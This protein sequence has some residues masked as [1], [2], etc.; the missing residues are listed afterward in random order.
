M[1]C[2]WSLHDEW[3]AEPISDLS[4]PGLF[5]TKNLL[6]MRG[7]M[8]NIAKDYWTKHNLLCLIQE[9]EPLRNIIQKSFKGVELS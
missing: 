5:P 7:D 6:P 9:P 3:V 2:P 4:P 1:T 8:N